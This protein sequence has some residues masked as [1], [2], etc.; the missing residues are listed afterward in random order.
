MTQFPLTPHSSSWFCWMSGHWD[1]PRGTSDTVV[2]VTVRHRPFLSRGQLLVQ[3][4]LAGQNA[5]SDY[6]VLILSGKSPSPTTQVL[7]ECSLGSI[8]EEGS[9]IL[10]EPEE[11]EEPE[12]PPSWY[13]MQRQSG[14]ACSTHAHM[15]AC[16][17]ERA[18]AHIAWERREL[19]ANKGT[20][21]RTGRAVGLS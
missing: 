18:H 15:C 19:V 20:S 14:C 9:E 10:Q 12:M 16:A 13:A 6:R 8:K 7:K 1:W 4:H 17:H 21:Q 5:E 3:R 2:A 11:G